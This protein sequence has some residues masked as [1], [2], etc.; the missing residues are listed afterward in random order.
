LGRTGSGPAFCCPSLFF[1]K[2]EG[3]TPFRF[4]LHVGDVGHTLVIGPTGAGKSVLLALMAMQFRRYSDNQIFAFDFGGSIRAACLGMG[5]DWQDLGGSGSG[6]DNDNGSEGQA[7]FLQPLARIDDPVERAWASGWIG[8]MLA[9]EGLMLEPRLK[10]LIWSAL[11][12][13]ASAPVSER[14]LTGLAVLLQDQSLKQA[15]AP[16]CLG[17]PWGRLLDAEEEHLGDAAVQAFETEG[18]VGSAS[19]GPV[20]SYLFHRIEDRL[21]GR[22]TLILIDEGWLVLDSPAFAA[23]LREWLKTLRKK[24]ASV[25]FATQ[26]LAD[27]ERSSIAPAIIESCP[28]R[29][30][31]PNERAGEPQIQ[32]IYRRF[33]LNDRQIGIIAQATPK[34]DYYVQSSRGNR[35][36]ELG[37]GEVAL[38]FAAASSKTDQRDIERLMAEHGAQGFAAAWLEHRDLGWAASMLVQPDPTGITASKAVTDAGHANL[39]EKS[40]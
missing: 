30:F 3:S 32:T 9:G 24:N 28:T 31:L 1:G 26:S 15:L 16:F 7:V 23:Q 11:T 40:A 4:S 6:N 19:A 2:T 20:L 38:A 8:A 12:S 18:L 34:R 17:G 36:F 13:L 29:L 39:R 35:L 22:P 14:T 33:G 5:G 21:D 37:L 27:V 25:I 10:E